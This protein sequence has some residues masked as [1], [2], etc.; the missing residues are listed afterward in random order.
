MVNFLVVQLFRWSC[1][2]NVVWPQPPYLLT[3]DLDWV[4]C[5][6]S[7]I[8]FVVIARPPFRFLMTHVP[9]ITSG[10]VCFPWIR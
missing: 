7:S 4:F 2:L 3:V 9:V 10:F 1:G 5:V 8:L 6:E